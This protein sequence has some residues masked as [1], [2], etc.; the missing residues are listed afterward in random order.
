[1]EITPTFKTFRFRGKNVG[2]CYPSPNPVWQCCH[3]ASSEDTGGRRGIATFDVSRWGC[4][5]YYT[6]LKHIS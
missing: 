5:L 2:F 6:V 3:S 4:S 1:M